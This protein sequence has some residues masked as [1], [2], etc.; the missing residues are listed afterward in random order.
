MKH[1][2]F[3]NAVMAVAAVVTASV[4]YA[5]PGTEGGQ[6][7]RPTFEQL[8]TDGNGEISKAEMQAHR[9]ARFANADANGDGKLS[10]EEMTVVGREKSA[11]RATRMIERFDADG[12]GALST[13]ELPQGRRGEKMFD[14]ADADG[15]GAISVEEFAALSEKMRS[16]GK[17][18][19]QGD[20]SEQN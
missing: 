17:H 19:H 12:D 2:V 6:G 11:K 4:V 13:Q 15:N 8:D 10:L 20:K 3:M 16:R 5:Q 1:T 18:K 7:Q 14:R 9:Q